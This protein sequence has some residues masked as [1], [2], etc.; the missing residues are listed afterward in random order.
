MDLS[1]KFVLPQ[2]FEKNSDESSEEVS[3][4]QGIE[5]GG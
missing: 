4:G 5:V 1:A 2:E 3:V